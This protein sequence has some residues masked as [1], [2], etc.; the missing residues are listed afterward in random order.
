MEKTQLTPPAPTLNVRHLERRE[1]LRMAALAAGA[2]LV[3]APSNAMGFFWSTP[4]NK[5]NANIEIPAEWIERFGPSVREYVSFLQ[6]LN[7]KHLRIEQLISAHMKERGKVKN[8]LPPK[9]LWRNIRPTL[10]AAD[11][12]AEK[13]NE[14]IRNIV[15]AY[16]SPRYNARCAGARSRSFHMHNMALDLQFRSSPRQVALAAR[17]LRE[18]GVFTG[19]VGRYSSFTHIDTRGK[20]ADW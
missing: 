2:L 9:A 1:F 17:E 13:L 10:K 12:L 5:A 6:R 15:S 16:R 18:K 8:S 11:R 19:G 4:R 14:P 20:K 7:L 3:A